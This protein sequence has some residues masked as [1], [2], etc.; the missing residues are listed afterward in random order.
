MQEALCCTCKTC[1]A[2][3]LR[4]PLDERAGTLAA[5]YISRLV[6]FYLLGITELVFCIPI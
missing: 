1:N 6:Y 4:K 2:S 5:F 3:N